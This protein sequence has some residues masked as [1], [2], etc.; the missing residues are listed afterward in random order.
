M[1]LGSAQTRSVVLEAA[2]A[3]A[4][5]GELDA[6][7]DCAVPGVVAVV[8]ACATALRALIRKKQMEAAAHVRIAADGRAAHVDTLPARIRC[9][10]RKPPE[11]SRLLAAVEAVEMSGLDLTISATF[12]VGVQAFPI[13]HHHLTRAERGHTLLGA[14]IGNG[15]VE[16]FFRQ[17]MQR[18]D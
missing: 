8:C 12:Q 10:P 17:S 9:A 16:I 11:A 7:A 1:L 6:V 14:S 18:D 4:A 3:G 13:V 5:T 2:D 15:L